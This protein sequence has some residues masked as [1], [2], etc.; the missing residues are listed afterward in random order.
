MSHGASE[1]AMPAVGLSAASHAFPT[2]SG[3]GS[4][5]PPKTS[6]SP[7]RFR[8]ATPPA[9]SSNNVRTVRGA[10]NPRWE[11]PPAK[12]SPVISSILKPDSWF[13]KSR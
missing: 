13:V 8:R 9:T 6:P 4:K 3:A 1:P 11:G 10:R 12:S 5:P 7:S 2:F